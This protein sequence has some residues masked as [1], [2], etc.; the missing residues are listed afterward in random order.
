MR[1][2]GCLLPAEL[3]RWRLPR[4]LQAAQG[5]EIMLREILGALRF[6]QLG[7]QGDDFLV[8]A[9]SLQR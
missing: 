2:A 5:I 7:R 8:S 9:A 3:L 4:L 1:V 6:K